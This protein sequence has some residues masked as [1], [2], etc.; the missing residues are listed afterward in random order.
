MLR[1]RKNETPPTDTSGKFGL[2][3]SKNSDAARTG[4]VDTYSTAPSRIIKA[5]KPPALK[6]DTRPPSMP[7]RVSKNYGT[8]IFQRKV[9]IRN[10][11]SS[12]GFMRDS[13]PSS[14]P[15]LT[16]NST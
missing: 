4:S 3:K 7:T 12:G 8:G 10:T 11:S 16:T 15:P 1:L 2:L 13:E 14:P 5:T 6:Q 9:D